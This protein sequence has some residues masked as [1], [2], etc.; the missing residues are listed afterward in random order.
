[1]ELLI[2]KEE[3]A[4][5]PPAETSFTP[6]CGQAVSRYCYTPGAMLSLLSTFRFPL[7]ILSGVY[8]CDRGIEAHDKCLL[9]LVRNPVAPP[10]VCVTRLVWGNSRL[11]LNA[12]SRPSF[13]IPHFIVRLTSRRAWRSGR[14]R[15][16]GDR[17]STMSSRRTRFFLMIVRAIAKSLLCPFGTFLSDRFFHNR[18]VSVLKT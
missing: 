6:N 8:F 3:A 5:P 10:Q 15:A 16:G 11:I 2:W 1:M 17:S 18:L 4:A 12:L 14:S 7:E 13:S 9:D